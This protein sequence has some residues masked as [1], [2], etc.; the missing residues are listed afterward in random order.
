MR[1]SATTREMVVLKRKENFFTS[2][3]DF[4]FL[5]IVRMGYWLSMNL[6]KINIAVFLLD[7]VI[8]A[9]FKL[10]IKVFEQWFAFLREKKEE[11]TS[12]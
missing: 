1:L 2:I 5:P 11:V 7:F 4:F 9:P 8:E 6:S 3:L 12:Q 10:V